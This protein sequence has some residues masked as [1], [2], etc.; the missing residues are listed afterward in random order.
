[1]ARGKG[2]PPRP[3]MMRGK[4]AIEHALNE[5]AR[6]E[7]IEALRDF[8]EA[9]KVK[10]SKDAVHPDKAK[11]MEFLRVKILRGEFRDWNELEETFKAERGEKGLEQLNRMLT[12]RD[13]QV[14]DKIFKHRMAIRVIIEERKKAKRQRAA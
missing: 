12:K 2:R 14:L 3:L 4:I 9:V 13:L 11:M 7:A 8:A 6:K 5:H 1:M 10:H